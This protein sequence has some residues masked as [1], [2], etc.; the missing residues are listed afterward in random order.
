MICLRFE[1]EA[2]VLRPDDDYV[3]L[4]GEYYLFADD[5]TNDCSSKKTYD[6]QQGD[7]DIDT[8]RLCDGSGCSSIPSSS[9]LQVYSSVEKV[10][11]IKLT[12]R[13]FGKS[14]I[15]LSYCSK[16]SG[17]SGSDWKVIHELIGSDSEPQFD[18]NATIPVRDDLGKL[19]FECIS[20]SGTSQCFIRNLKIIHTT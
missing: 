16:T 19:K 8:V 7:V 9:E 3:C 13:N 4:D 15:I 10:K 20:N 2:E 6:E 11:D 1:D 17:C 12:W 18:H 5:T 14:E